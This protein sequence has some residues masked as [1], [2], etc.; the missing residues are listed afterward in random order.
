MS[1]AWIEIRACAQGYVCNSYVKD[2]GSKGGGSS[3]D[4]ILLEILEREMSGPTSRFE[5]ATPT[6][7][8]L[9]MMVK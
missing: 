6:L 2:Q 9:V 4:I 1:H 7:A 5:L 8:I 3:L